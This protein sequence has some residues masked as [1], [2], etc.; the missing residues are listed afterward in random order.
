M[1]ELTLAGEQLLIRAAELFC[2]LQLMSVPGPDADRAELDGLLD[3]ARRFRSS[4]VIAELLGM[5]VAVRL[6][7][8]RRAVPAD[9]GGLLLELR[10]SAEVSGAPRLIGH[11]SALRARHGLLV[12]GAGPDRGRTPT[13]LVDAG[14]ALALLTDTTEHERDDDTP[15]GTRALARSLDALVGALLAIGAHEI[16]DEVSQRAVAVADRAGSAP[17]RLVH[18]L[19]RVRLE[20]SWGLRLEREGQ[21]RAAAARVTSAARSAEL[22]TRMGVVAGHPGRT[23]DP[24]P[25]PIVGAACALADPDPRHL[26]V[27]AVLSRTA[28]SDDDRV[29][30]AVATA[31]CLLAGGRPDAAA[32]ALERLRR[33]LHDLSA[34]CA[35]VLLREATLVDAASAP[36]VRSAYRGTALADYAAGLE[37]EIAALHDAELWALRSHRDKLRLS[38]DHGALTAQVLVDPLTGLLNRRALDLRLAEATRADRQPCAVALIDLDRFKDVNDGRSHAVGDVVLREIATTLRGALRS[39]DVVVRYG[40][41]E[42]VVI[43]P[44]TPLAEASAALTRAARAI[45]EL[46]IEVASGVTMSVGVVGALPDAEPA[47][48]LAAAD[49]AMYRA[50]HEGGNKVISAPAV[51]SPRTA[52]QASR[53]MST[54]TSSA[55][56]VPP[57]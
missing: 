12:G 50:K 33:G 22:T 18:Q 1:V 9:T 48:A 37:R 56:A 10:E 35:L 54:V 25:L 2:G 6:N 28:Q 53:V 8:G 45:A 38:R 13:P 41:D 24:P 29:A 3:H 30:V 31:R 46:P 19:S 5:A 43:M 55:A 36:D 11:A 34:G 7:A 26:D 16:A 47:A 40:G 23:A 39:Q 20:V 44:S 17:E 52:G 27:L 42:F 14:E 32:A 51:P 15:T 4:T 57:E 49:A 21:A